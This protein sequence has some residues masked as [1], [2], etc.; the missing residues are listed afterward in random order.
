MLKSSETEHYGKVLTLGSKPKLGLTENIYLDSHREIVDVEAG[1][2][3][4]HFQHELDSMQSHEDVVG[5]EEG[6][7][8]D[9]K[10]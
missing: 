6:P 7:A 4:Q 8:N 1:P 2:F 3:L 9:L 5:N 10:S